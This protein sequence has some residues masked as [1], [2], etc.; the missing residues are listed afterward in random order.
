MKLASLEEGVVEPFDASESSISPVSEVD[1]RVPE[2]EDFP[3]MRHRAAEDR[4]MSPKLAKL[5][6][7]VPL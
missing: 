7:V 3:V 5:S 6:K 4:S 1:E 2:V